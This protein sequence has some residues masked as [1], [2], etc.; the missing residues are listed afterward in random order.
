MAPVHHFAYGSVNPVLAFVLSFIGSLLSLILARQARDA[1]GSQ[2]VRY[3]IL[4][5]LSLG[6]TGIWLMH[7]MAMVGFDVPDSPV[8]YDLPI[9]ALSFAIA[10]VIVAVGLFTAIFTR[11]GTLKVVTGGVITGIGVAAMHYT[12]MLSM[13][14]GG[15]IS[16]DLKYVAASVGV[17]VV[18]ATVAL[19][20]AAV[21]RGTTA[22][23]GAALI[24]AVAV[25]SMHYTGM[26]AIRVRLTDPG[27]RVEGLETFELLAPIAIIACVMI[28]GLAYATVSSTPSM[29]EAPAGA[30]HRRVVADRT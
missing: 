29:E 18:A 21:L 19:W 23:V 12:G 16:F 10:V 9:T 25:C 24:M 20:F 3:L 4:S 5:A 15:K 14:V 13:Q 26:L 6:G 8:R 2:R 27:A 11:P 1:R 28:M 30:H 17:A 7:F 22:M